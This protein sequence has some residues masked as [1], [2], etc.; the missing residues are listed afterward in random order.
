MY[1]TASDY[2]LKW[3][4]KKRRKPL[5]IRG[6]RQVGKSYLVSM[7][8][9][10]N[11][12]D[13]IEVNF[14]R[15]PEM[16]SL[17]T[18]TSEKIIQ[19]LELKFNKKIDT[20]NT[21]LF[22]DEIQAAPEVFAKLR[23]FYEDIP[24]LHVIAAG[25]LL[26]FLLDNHT[27]S[28]PVGRIEYLHLGPMTFEEF[29]TAN[30]NTM[31][32]DFIQNFSLSED[33]P[34]PVHYDL[35]SLFKSFLIIGGMPEAVSAFVETQS[36]HESEIVKESI[37]GTY[38]DDFNKYSSRVNHVRI[39]KVFKKLPLM[40]GEKFKYV[41]VDKNERAKNI[42]E[43]LHVL[44][45]ARIVFRINHSACNGVPLGAEVNEKKFKI[46]FLDVGLMVS[47]CGMSMLDIENAD[48][49]MMVNSGRLCEQFVGQH[50]LYLNEYYKKPELYY[51]AREAKNSS[52][53]VDY[54]IS[55]GVKIIPVEVKAGKTGRLKSLH[56][57]VKEKNVDLSV[58]INLAQPSIYQE[59]NKV[60]GGKT[61]EYKLLSIPFYL[62]GQVNR[63]V[64]EAMSQ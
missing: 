58:R 5:V 39:L 38:E 57:F 28:M 35:I 51:W 8:A 30:G 23:Y 26:E 32:V 34:V 59:S 17:F 61:I 13:F 11:F 54:V 55:S 48:N 53:E 36:Y 24:E 21:L 56:Q 60:S 40:V 42:A 31:L 64:Q 9:E 27:F 46:T 37:I 47:A 44:E 33:V 50:L 6:A 14:E 1:R 29:L 52:A 7:F 45:M 25:S 19:L 62:I 12:S 10:Q 16:K 63:L 3:K 22:L 41:N 49:V 2:L 43:A 18:G 20:K 15:N 4:N